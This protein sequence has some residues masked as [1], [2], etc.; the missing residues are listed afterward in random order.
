MIM[1][2]RASLCAFRYR[3]RLE[4]RKICLGHEMELMSVVGD[5]GWKTT[6]FVLN[7]ATGNILFTVLSPMGQSAV[8][9]HRKPI[10]APFARQLIS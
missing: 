6:A 7:K 1:E 5:F 4:L 9:L 3:D 10:Q 2:I 8:R